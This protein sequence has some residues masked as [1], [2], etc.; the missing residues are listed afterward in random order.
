MA[1]DT[2][3]TTEETPTTEEQTPEETSTETTPAVVSE[4]SG[5]WN[6]LANNPVPEGVI[7]G[8]KRQLVNLAIWGLLVFLTVGAFTRRK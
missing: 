1:D 2:T 5:V 3:D 6:F 4:N 7:D 8:D